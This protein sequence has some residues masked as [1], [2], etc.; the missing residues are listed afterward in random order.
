MSTPLLRFF[1][2]PG[3][4]SLFNPKDGRSLMFIIPPQNW[5]M[6]LLRGILA[7]IFGLLCVVY[8]NVT[9]FVMKIMF[10]VYALVDG[11]FALASSIP[12]AKG[13]P[14]RWSTLLEG[15]VGV[16]L[17]LLI[18]I[19]PGITVFGLLYLIGAWAIITGIFE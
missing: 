13:C 14:R 18:L 2:Q 11:I 9:L 4:V 7:V 16:T 12:T 19:W 15:I 5:W 8:P 17:G 3:D 6:L 10:G 1:A